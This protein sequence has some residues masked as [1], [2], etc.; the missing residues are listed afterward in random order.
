M[1]Y[2]Y[3]VTQINFVHYDLSSPSAI[4]EVQEL[5][6]L[7]KN[8]QMLVMVKSQAI[9]R[10]FDAAVAAAETLDVSSLP[11]PSDAAYAAYVAACAAV[12]A[13][14]RQWVTMDR[15]NDGVVRPNPQDSLYDATELA[16]SRAAREAAVNAA[17]ARRRERFAALLA[18]AISLRDAQIT[19]ML[20]KVDP[21]A[22]A[23]FDA[24]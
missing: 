22:K 23:A 12:T 21:T 9:V 15:W 13:F 24:I 6:G 18:L 3:S 11:H 17:G 19:T 2:S 10:E 16:S 4:R 20:T 14:R 5:T 8:V 7:P 1:S